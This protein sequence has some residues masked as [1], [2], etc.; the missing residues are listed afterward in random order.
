M[1]SIFLY[2]VLGGIFSELLGL[3]KLRHKAPDHFPEWLRSPF[4]WI[5][6]FIMIIVGGVLTVIYSKAG[7]NL[8]PL[9]AV[10]IGASAPLLISSFVA[11]TPQAIKSD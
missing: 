5:I 9:V 6:T 7:I 2:G 3:F 11:H 10:N 1:C 4:Y 8:N